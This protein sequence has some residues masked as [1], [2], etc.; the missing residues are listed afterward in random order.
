M[1]LIC[2]LVIALSGSLDVATEAQT[3]FVPVRVGIAVGESVE[4]GRSDETGKA[5]VESGQVDESGRPIWVAPLNGSPKTA[6]GWVAAEVAPAFAGGPSL[7]VAGTVARKAA[8]SNASPSAST[9]QEFGNAYGEQAAGNSPIRYLQN[10]SVYAGP[11]VDAGSTNNLGLRANQF[12]GNAN[13]ASAAPVFL[14]PQPLLGRSAFRNPGPFRAW[15]TR[16]RSYFRQVANTG[17]VNSGMWLGF[18]PLSSN[19]WNQN[20]ASGSSSVSF[21]DR[22]FPGRNGSTSGTTQ[23]VTLPPPVTAP[24]SSTLGV[25]STG[26]PS[27]NQSPGA[28]SAAL[29][30]TAFQ[31]PT[32][33]NNSY[34]IA[35]PQT[36]GSN[37]IAP[38]ATTS[39]DSPSNGFASGQSGVPTSGINASAG[40]YS[41]YQPR[42]ESC[43]SQ[44]WR[45]WLG[46][47]YTTSS[48]RV[49]VTYY[50]P[51]TTTDP[52]TGQQ[53]TVQQPCTSFVQQSQRTPIR[54]FRTARPNLSSG[55]TGW[56][57]PDACPPGYVTVANSGLFYPNL[58]YAAA[59]TV[60]PTSSAYVLSAGSLSPATL[61]HAPAALAYGVVP[62]TGG[63][64]PASAQVAMPN[65]PAVIGYQSSISANSYSDS[66]TRSDTTGSSATS[67]TRPLTAADLGEQFPSSNT[68]A[69]DFTPMNPPQL[70]R[71]ERPDRLPGD[72]QDLNPGVGAR[73]EQDDSRSQTN[74]PPEIDDFSSR[75]FGR[76]DLTHQWRL[77]DPSDSTALLHSRKH[78][79]T[80]R[81]FDGSMKSGTQSES[82][83]HSETEAKYDGFGIQPGVDVSPS[84]ETLLRN[85][86][87]V[88]AEPIV[89][90][91]DYQP[92]YS[93][94]EALETNAKPLPSG[95]VERSASESNRM[96]G[97]RHS[98]SK[99]SSDLTTISTTSR[100]RTVGSGS[101]I[102]NR[103]IRQPQS[104]K[105][106]GQSL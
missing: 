42:S 67:S 21:F 51:V 34:Q 11:S 103:F 79:S 65:Q 39:R 23:P 70:E 63:V 76:S 19:S 66:A 77:Q 33:T 82:V 57:N 80:L 29:Q 37:S 28:T 53:V 54:L 88:R 64:V 78:Q 89:A 91:S 3:P 18:I 55:G 36:P 105:S 104:K 7:N 35:G 26:T 84:L 16:S 15:Q 74:P 59:R 97:Q 44:F 93:R 5:V 102:D 58:G 75:S 92:L 17:S 106:L 98:D 40:Q 46:T 68:R 95:E 1:R 41:A 52:T 9:S 81:E 25:S 73:D 48:Y 56:G 30:V 38:V 50:R 20:D 12:V 69:S 45:R 22:L 86:N 101:G 6:S 2:C 62:W 99:A 27:F 61:T 83:I 85:E 10:P 72:A 8:S 43:W 13:A 96:N 47:G 94:R 4:T 32:A 60:L 24:V 49:P 31:N 71:V 100:S 87:F 14:L 90:P